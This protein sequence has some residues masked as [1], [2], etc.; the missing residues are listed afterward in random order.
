MK[1]PA[2]LRST[3]D[4]ARS[5]RRR[6]LVRIRSR[7]RALPLRWEHSPAPSSAGR[8]PRPPVES[9]PPLSV[10]IPVRNEAARL[11]LLLADLA[12]A[13]ASLL[14]EVW[15]VDG[16]SGDGSAR[17]A[18]LAGAR[19]LASPAGRGEQLRRGVAVSEGP[20]L[21]LLHAD[22]RLPAGW[23]AEIQRAI[24]ADAQAAWAFPLTIEAAGP[25]LRLVGAL[26]TLR[27][28][29]RGLPYGDQGLLIS[30]ALYERS[31]GLAPLPLMEDLEFMLRLRELAPIRLLRRPLQVD[32]RRWRRLGVWRTTWRNAL[33]RRAWRRGVDPHLLARRY[34]GE[35]GGE[36][37]GEA[38]G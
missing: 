16:G 29:W 4:L 37:G 38:G 19:T 34:Y 24:R 6:I 31:G 9:L 13:P 3:A 32:G 10:V 35:A 33:L 5:A 11:P 8:R 30:R 27:S 1:V 26:S 36:V 12:A 2:P 22:A 18:R 28:R 17:L 23:P 14:R 15:A 25:A 20:W 7:G 21:L